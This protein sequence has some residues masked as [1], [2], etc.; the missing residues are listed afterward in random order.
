MKNRT[1]VY[2]D[3]YLMK[4]VKW[5]ALEKGVSAS[6]LISDALE[7]F[8]YNQQMANDRPQDIKYI[9]WGYPKGGY[10]FEHNHGFLLGE[11]ANNEGFY[12]IL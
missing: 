5:Y 7:F 3:E 11:E 4:E 10:K 1:T 2:L 9:H 12:R 6:K 8:V